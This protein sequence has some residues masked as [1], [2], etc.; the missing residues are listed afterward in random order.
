MTKK[1]ITWNY[2]FQNVG[3]FIQQPWHTYLKRY[4]IWV[5][6]SG[7]QK[8]ETQHRS[9]KRVTVIEL[10]ESPTATSQN[11]H[12]Q[13]TGFR[14]EL[15]HTLRHSDTGFLCPPSLFFHRT[16]MCLI[17]CP[18]QVNTSRGLPD[19]LWYL[20]WFCSANR[21]NSIFEIEI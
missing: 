14:A 18:S 10:L 8:P 12:E 4:P 7:K 13:E 9:P 20:P 2:G 1:I 15:C 5:R 11:S 3:V 21:N 16:S 19:F 6:S 17:I